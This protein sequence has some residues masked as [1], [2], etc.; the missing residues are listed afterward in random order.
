MG[1]VVSDRGTKSQIRL[2]AGVILVTFP[3]WMAVQWV[4]GQMGWDP[5]YVFLADLSAL[6][7]FGWALV[8]LYLAWRKG[9]DNEG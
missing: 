5:S 9:R 1:G 6:A 3:V 7:A 4:G 8:V 2:A